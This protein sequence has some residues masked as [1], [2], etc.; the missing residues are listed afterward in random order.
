M[1]NWEEETPVLLEWIVS[2]LKHRPVGTKYHPDKNT[3]IIDTKIFSRLRGMDLKAEV[4]KH[5]T[6]CFQQH[7]RWME[8]EEV[9]E[10]PKFPIGNEVF[11]VQR[12]NNGSNYSIEV[13]RVKKAEV[14][15]RNKVLEEEQQ[16]REVKPSALSK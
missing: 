1:R 5:R 4:E 8:K 11:L 10:I 15:K 12:K 16:T 7:M 14:F 13:H 9:I 2:R 3:F 6:H